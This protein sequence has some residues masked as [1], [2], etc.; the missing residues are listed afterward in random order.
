M[1]SGGCKSIICVVVVAAIGAVEKSTLCTRLFV[2]VCVYECTYAK[3]QST[4]MTLSSG[5]NHYNHLRPLLCEADERSKRAKSAPLVR[6]SNKACGQKVP[7]FELAANAQ[8]ND[9][10]LRY[11][12]TQIDRTGLGGSDGGGGGGGGRSN[13]RAFDRSDVCVCMCIPLLD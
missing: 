1:D 5:K 9:A 6:P 13:G 7:T 8:V 11:A 4:K 10:N 12:P 3:V 2:C